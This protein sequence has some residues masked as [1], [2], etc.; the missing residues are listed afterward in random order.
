MVLHF[1]IN[2]RVCLVLRNVGH[3]LDTRSVTDDMLKE[4]ETHTDLALEANRGNLQQL[5]GVERKL[6]DDG[7]VKITT[8]RVV[9][10]QAAQQIGKPIGNYI[11]LEA[12]GLRTK[13]EHLQEHVRRCFAEELQTLVNAVSN[14]AN[15]KV[16]VI[17]LGNYR[18]TPDALGPLVVE[19]VQVTRHYFETMPQQ[20]ENHL[21]PVSAIAPGVLGTTGIETSEI[22]KGIVDNVKPDLV[23]AIDALASRSLMRVH[24]TIQMTDVGI[25][26]GSGV[27]NRRK[28][29]NRETLGVPV[30][31]IGVPTVVYASTIVHQAMELLSEHFR[32]HIPSNRKILGILDDISDE[33]RIAVVKEVLE[34]LGQDMLVTP[35]D[36]DSF[37]ADMSLVIANGINQILH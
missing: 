33:E 4:F 11:T 25:E 23:I 21:R 8:I 28:A 16:L 29:L 3:T 27:G 36:I 18:V 30:I 2:D 10:E 22:V 35:K 14:H 7:K 13:D 5:S 31:A 32:Q 37:M 17:G 6:R 26:P 20:V 9:D 12:P 1:C 24:T 19:H 34:P 15:A